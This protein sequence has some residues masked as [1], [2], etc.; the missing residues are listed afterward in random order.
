MFCLALFDQT[1]G[2]LQIK[3]NQN[4][5]SSTNKPMITLDR[6]VMTK[7]LLMTPAR[8]TVTRTWM[9]S[10]PHCWTRT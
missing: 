1:E 5:F 7:Q 9:M 2:F 10:G 6:P 4:T 8:K 3:Q